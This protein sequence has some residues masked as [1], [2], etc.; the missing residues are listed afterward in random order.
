M[1]AGLTVASGAVGGGHRSPRSSSGN[2]SW[3]SRE[4]SCGGEGAVRKGAEASHLRG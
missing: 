4:E 2:W 1:E 3:A